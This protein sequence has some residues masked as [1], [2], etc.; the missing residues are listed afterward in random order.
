MPCEE[1]L[2]V[3][4]KAPRP[5][6]VKTRLARA[7]GA[8][9]ACDAYR[10]LVTVLLNQLAAVQGL[11]LCY[12]PDDALAEIKPWLREGWRSAPQGDGNLGD[13]L[14]AA[15][16]RAFREG[17]LRVVII[18]SDCPTVTPADIHAAWD[19]LRSHD[20][21]LGPASDGGYWLLGLRRPQ[22]SLFRDIPWGDA[23]VLQRTLEHVSQ[24]GLSVALLRE[25]R[26][27]DTVED[28]RSFLGPR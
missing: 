25:Q 28:W 5:G 3:F 21:V 18:G 6:S 1:K 16:D 26:D 2:I 9:A 23:T 27:I 24:S 14:G 17:A 20:V 4:L 12:S 11:E 10:R 13:R 7:L 19:G 8:E 22:P 15:F